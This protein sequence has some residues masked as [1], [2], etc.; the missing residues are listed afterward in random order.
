M[1][2]KADV[3]ITAYEVSCLPVDHE[4][5]SSFSLS[6]KYVGRDEWCVLRGSRVIDEEGRF[7]RATFPLYRALS[8]AQK[9]ASKITV[10]GL[11]VEKVIKEG[12][13]R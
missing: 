10:N 13:Q 4:L 7:L 6:V 1:I 2:P 9:H 5:R 3:L 12:I 8:I 11:T